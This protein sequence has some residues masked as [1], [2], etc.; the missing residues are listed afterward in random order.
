MT[1]LKDKRES[2]RKES[3]QKNVNITFLMVTLKATDDCLRYI[4]ISQA[5]MIVTSRI[6]NNQ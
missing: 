6:R 5:N 1:N 4:L 2:E 3:K